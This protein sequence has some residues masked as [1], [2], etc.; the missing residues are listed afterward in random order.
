MIRIINRQR[1]IKVNVE[2]LRKATEQMITFLGYNDFDIG[3]LLTTNK[4]I[5]KFNQ[6]YCNKNTPTDILSFPFHP[7]YPAGT[8][9]VIQNSDDKNLGDIIISLEYIKKDTSEDKQL[10]EKRLL[11]LLAHGIIHLLNYNHQTD[12]DF[13]IMQKIEKQL[14]DFIKKR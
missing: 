1:T 2:S 13:V 5:R 3:I 10:L 8:L 12:E 7:N 9:P 4:T 11:I 14:L 6:K